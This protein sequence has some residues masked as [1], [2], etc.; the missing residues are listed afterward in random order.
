MDRFIHSSTK[1]LSEAIHNKEVSSYEVVTACISRIEAVN[2][3]IN[4]VVQKTFEEAIE[5]A[6]QADN[7]L[8]RGDNWGLLHGVPMTIKDSLDTAGVV[9]TAG[10]KGRATYMPD[11]DATV[12]ARLRAAG[13]ILVGKTNTPELTVAG[14]TDNHI[15]GQT[16]NPYDLNRTP[17]GSS[18]GAAAI[19]ATGAIPFDI[20]SDSSG[21]VRLPAHYCGIAGLKPTLGRVPRTGHILS[22]EIG[23]LDPYTHIGPLA[24]YVEDL[25]LLLSIIA[26]VDWYDPTIVPIALGN[27]LDVDLRQLRVA[28]YRD[29]GIKTST[30]DTEQVIQQTVEILFASGLTLVEDRPPG[31]EQ[32]EGLAS[33][34][35]LA[36]GGAA[37]RK[38]LQTSG[39]ALAETHSSIRWT[40]SDRVLP[41]L[42]LTALTAQWNIFR[43][44][45]LTFMR[46]YDAII[47]PASSTPAPPHET[48]DIDFS[49]T[50]P[51][52]L[53]GWPAVVVRGGTSSEGLPI[54]VQV[55]ASPW[56]EDVACAIAQQIEEELGGW[57]LPSVSI[58]D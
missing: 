44:H 36:D 56:R 28:Y 27:P 48:A 4:A 42:G 3:K 16:N 12:V 22:F 32:A 35:I 15:Y 33:N 49:Y 1:T 53:T 7:A 31:I 50:V 11:K 25:T 46:E 8:R 23:L 54:G 24:R 14:I 29:N 18:G 2:P 45:M 47:C 40:Q 9:T 41:T 10:T 38:L 17:G 34:L 52:N 6:R 51:Y 30:S 58:G 19:V 37:I 39:T 26:G 43:S 5:Q 13:A 21:S 20:G 55:I 57:Q